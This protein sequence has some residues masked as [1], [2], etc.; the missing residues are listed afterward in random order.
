MN[1]ERLIH[2]LASDLRSTA[3]LPRGGSKLAIMTVLAS[4][5][6]LGAIL[7]LFSRSPHF[8]HGPSATIVFSAA[9]G[10]AL[11]VIAFRAVLKSGYPEEGTGLRSFL[12]PPAILL[13]GLVLELFRV[14]EAS[15]TNRLWGQDSTACF[16]CVVVLSL[17]ILAAVLIALRDS[18]PTRPWLSGAMAG[19]LAGG[20]AAALYTLHCPE[21]SL[22]FVATWH[23]LAIVTVSVCGALVARRF[24]RW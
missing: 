1:T 22:L 12:V 8:E 4:M 3:G 24:L 5:V 6:T 17:P 11:A 10:L 2:D 20:I 23:V 18:A 15:W 13:S 14:P 19:L 16:C 7:L 9:A 21:D